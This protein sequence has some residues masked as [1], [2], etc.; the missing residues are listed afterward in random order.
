MGPGF[1]SQRDHKAGTNRD[2]DRSDEMSERFFLFQPFIE[3]RSKPKIR[4]PIRGPGRFFK[5]GPRG[6]WQVR[7]RSDQTNSGFDP[8][9]I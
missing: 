8:F 4:G 9:E 3:Q 1:E 2:Q 7:M 5:I 6:C